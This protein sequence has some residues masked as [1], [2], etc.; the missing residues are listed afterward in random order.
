MYVKSAKQ[1]SLVTS[2]SKV[3]PCMVYIRIYI[4]R[5]LLDPISKIADSCSGLVDV[6]SLARRVDFSRL[7]EMCQEGSHQAI[8]TM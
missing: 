3:E 6:C 8:Y 2:S 5:V 4:L 7:C 1:A